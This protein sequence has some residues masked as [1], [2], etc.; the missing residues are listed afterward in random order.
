[1]QAWSRH[2]CEA[3]IVVVTRL[4]VVAVVVSGKGK[5]RWPPASNFPPGAGYVGIPHHVPYGGNYGS[6]LFNG[7]HDG[8]YAVHTFNKGVLGNSMDSKDLLFS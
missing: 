4:C 3:G 2:A 5:K 1:M 7:S 8:E 6:A